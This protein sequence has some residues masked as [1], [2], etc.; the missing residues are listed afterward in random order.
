MTDLDP[1]SSLPLAC[2]LGPQDGR[3]R[4][5]RWEALHRSAAPVSSLRHGVLEVR[6]PGAPGVLAELSAL[7][8][9]EQNCCTFVDWSVAQAGG[10]AVLT[11]RAPAGQPEAVEPI[12]A[13]F[14][15]GA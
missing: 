10:D 7:A 12:A 2:T 4:L 13:L 9:A 15:T 8:A 6:Y 11:V 3:D 1:G 5:R 14:A